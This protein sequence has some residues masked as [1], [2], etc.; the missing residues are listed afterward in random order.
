MLKKL[1]SVICFSI[2]FQSQ[3]G[4]K[5]NNEETRDL[6]GVLRP[7][8]N[9]TVSGY[10]YIRAKSNEVDFGLGSKDGALRYYRVFNRTV[11]VEYISIT[12][13]EKSQLTIPYIC[14]YKTA[15]QNGSIKIVNG[16]ED[17]D[18]IT[19]NLEIPAAFKKIAA[20]RNPTLFPNADK[21][22][23]ISSGKLISGWE[24]N[25]KFTR[26]G[27][28][29]R[30]QLFYKK[31]GAKLPPEDIA[32]DIKFRPWLDDEN[33]PIFAESKGEIFEVVEGKPID[34]EKIIIPFWTCGRTLEFS[35]D[36]GAKV[37]LSERYPLRGGRTLKFSFGKVDNIVLTMT[38]KPD[39]LSFPCG[40]MDVAVNDKTCCSSINIG[41]LPFMNIEGFEG[42]LV[43]ANAGYIDTPWT[44]SADKKLANISGTGKLRTDWKA[45]IKSKNNSLNFSF[46]KGNSTERSGLRLH[47]PYWVVGAKV[48]LELPDGKILDNK[49]DI[50][51]RTGMNLNKNINLPAG[52]K[53]IIHPTA[54]E[55]VTITTDAPFSLAFYRK[56]QASYNAAFDITFDKSFY[57]EKNSKGIINSYS[58]AGIILAADI[59]VFGINVGYSRSFKKAETQYPKKDISGD[60]IRITETSD[61]INVNSAYWALSHSKSAGNAISQML[62][63]YGMAKNIL[64]APEKIYIMQD[65]KEFSNISDKN[66][67]FSI[68]HQ[69]K[70]IKVKGELTA[71][72]GKKSGIKYEISYL[73]K[74]YTIERKVCFDFGSGQ[75]IQKVG[76]LN[77]ALS[78]ELDQCGYKPCVAEV[79]KAVFPG[80][81]VL[82]GK[83]IDSGYISIFKTGYEGIDFV[84]G[85]DIY[86][87]QNQITQEK[88]SAFFAVSGNEKGGASLIVEPY[89]NENKPIMISG[90]KEY[91]HYLGIPIIKEYIPR[92]YFYYRN[93]WGPDWLTDDIIKKLHENG[94]NLL[95]SGISRCAVGALPPQNP[96]PADAKIIADIKRIVKTAHQEG[97]MVIPFVSTLLS[98][99]VPVYQERAKDWGIP[100]GNGIASCGTYGDYMCHEADGWDEYLINQFM[101]YKNYFDYDGIYFDFIFPTTCSHPNH[102]A[103]G[104]KHLTTETHLRFMENSRKKLDFIL[105]HT[106]Y[107]PT[108]MLEDL[109]DMVWVGE[110]MPTWYSEEGKIPDLDR[111]REHFE[112]VPNTQRMVEP[113]VIYNYQMF[114]KN[115]IGVLRYR[116]EDAMEYISKLLLCGLFTF[117]SDEYSGAANTQE[118]FERNKPFL[119]VSRA[120]K[121]IDFSQYHFA[122]WKNQ[123][124]VITS[125]PRIRTALY[126]NGKDAIIIAANSECVS[127]EKTTIFVSPEALDWEKT[128]KCRVMGKEL[129][130]EEISK[131]GM[132][133]SLSCFAHEIIKIENISPQK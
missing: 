26:D 11:L 27:G 62:F 114:S 75:M 45:E 10:P 113:R 102:T 9:R 125:N 15:W 16:N 133:I 93:A 84:P 24:N 65:G 38:D 104:K 98:R 70:E 39:S 119:D 121:G 120:F 110:E 85:K 128:G 43:Q 100:A 19:G 106:G 33:I 67:T 6:D 82:C 44:I 5:K 4:D 42:N 57:T 14:D 90:I 116:K 28:I 88:N 32:I 111:I 60:E 58:G 61:S 91:K 101:T 95:C 99:K 54:T 63:N 123:A 52:S 12:E 77:L 127:E 18:K 35:A 47:F 74:P 51:L 87:W 92:Q 3:A 109:C 40:A 129:T 96:E 53:I 68:D 50:P 80:N 8:E 48:E 37:N 49:D 71:A 17:P 41:N 23:L 81:P 20:I 78:H 21:M 126:W 112:V 105:G 30:T 1:M 107:Y 79:K 118:L 130:F 22:E 31:T 73:Y 25:I 132:E 69:N 34:C 55:K 72:A 108:F 56:N 29:S 66:S 2:I 131:I 89:S 76:V 46:T 86:G 13:G 122:D 7:V 115:E 117:P 97:M 103:T 83:M 59:P 36:I 124:A 64:V 94:V